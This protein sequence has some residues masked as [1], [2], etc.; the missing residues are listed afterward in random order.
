MKILVTGANGQLGSELQALAT[1]TGWE[2]TFTDREELDITDRSAVLSFFQQQQFTHC[3]N[4]AAYTAVDKAEEDKDLTLL[5]N[6]TAVEYL[7]EACKEFG[8]ELIQIST[9]FVFDGKAHLPLK[10]DQAVDPVNHYGFTKWKG[11]QAA[12]D[13]MSNVVVIRTSW[14]YSRFG[15]NFVKTMQRLGKERDTLGVIVDQ[16]G[17]P[18]NAADLADAIVQVIPQLVK[19]HTFGGI[20]HYSNEGVASWYDF[21]HEIFHQSNIT[22]DLKPLATFQFPTP[23]ARP[24]YSVMD[25]SKIKETFGIA[26]AHWKDS[27]KI[28]IDQLA[29]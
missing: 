12:T 4:C 3:V 9:D 2:W 10:E 29:N 23:A 6:A 24:H 28:C 15:N 8:A 7:A 14:L 26:I 18:T 25:K 19:D 16:V 5:L 13:L 27:L 21:A 11:E 1:T 17:T 20:Y 22:V